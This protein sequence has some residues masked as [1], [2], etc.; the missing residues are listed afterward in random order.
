M[1][2]TYDMLYKPNIIFYHSNVK[3]KIDEKY[4][5]EFKDLL[6]YYK[7]YTEKLF[8]EFDY[9]KEKLIQDIDNECNIKYHHYIKFH[10][11]TYFTFDDI[12]DEPY[13]N[14]CLLYKVYNEITGKNK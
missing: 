3:N 5:D 8:N 6:R 9:K 14:D 10:Y 2:I 4:D 1:N 7:K 12:Y 11:D 13:I